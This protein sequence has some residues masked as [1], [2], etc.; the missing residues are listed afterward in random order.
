MRASSSG[1]EGQKERERER[2]REVEESLRS[3]DKNDA[4]LFCMDL[5][6]PSGSSRNSPEYSGVS[7]KQGRGAANWGPL[8][9]S[10]ICAIG[11]SSLQII[12]TAMRLGHQC[13]GKWDAG[14]ELVLY[15]VASVAPC[16]Y[17]RTGPRLQRP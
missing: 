3:L 14:R 10:A 16:A 6:Q 1:E 15:G 7:K 12:A 17:D 4:A 2:R 8:C 9:T 5:C 13:C 11:S